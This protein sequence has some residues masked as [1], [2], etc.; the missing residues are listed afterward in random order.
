MEADVEAEGETAGVLLIIYSC[1]DLDVEGIG[2]FLLVPL[3]GA[4]RIN[5]VR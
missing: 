5:I 2:E 1:P 4:I 3:Y